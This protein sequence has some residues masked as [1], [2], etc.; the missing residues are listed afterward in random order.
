M[1]I[2]E[3]RVIKKNNYELILLT[4]NNLFQINIYGN[5]IL[6]ESEFFLISKHIKDLKLKI[7][8]KKFF[9]KKDIK[10]IIRFMKTDKKN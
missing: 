1:I 10:K 6:N 3:I 5:N 8:L 4:Y 9:K 2:V 7:N